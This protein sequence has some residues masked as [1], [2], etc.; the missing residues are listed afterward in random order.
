MIFISIIEFLFSIRE[1]KIYNFSSSIQFIFNEKKRAFFVN[2]LL[3]EKIS[4]KSLLINL[5]ELLT[6]SIEI[7]NNANISENDAVLNDLMYEQK[8]LK[9]LLNF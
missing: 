9:K 5:F 8:C 4:Y 6:N 2:D 7:L 1:K 3:I